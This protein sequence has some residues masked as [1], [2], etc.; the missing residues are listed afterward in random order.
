MFGLMPVNYDLNVNILDMQENI[1]EAAWLDYLAKGNGPADPIELLRFYGHEASDMLR[2]VD[3]NYGQLQVRKF[4]EVMTIYGRCWQ[5]QVEFRQMLQSK[6]SLS[7]C[8]P[9][10]KN[11]YL[12]QL[13]LHVA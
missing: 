8:F 2:R 1:Y 11:A 9:F 7:Y 6:S 12:L 4:R 5:P 3:I 13:L 10:Q